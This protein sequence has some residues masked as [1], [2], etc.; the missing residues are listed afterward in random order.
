MSG[1]KNNEIRTPET[2]EAERYEIFDSPSY[3]FNIE[4]RDFLKA[5][6]GGVG[7]FLLV[8]APAALAQRGRESGGSR[9]FHM[10]PLP[11]NVGAWLH[12]APGGAVTVYT[13][14]VEIG[15]NIRTSLA[16]QVAQEL[17]VKLDTIT[18]VMGD[19]TLVPWDIGTFGSLTTPTMGPQLRRVGAVARD[20][21]IE[22]AA[23]RWRANK[24][25][26]V[27]ENGT[28]RDP[29][30]GRSIGYGALAEGQT[31]AKTILFDDP[32]MS[33]TKWTIAGEP[34]P[35]VGA[36]NFVTGR[37]LYPYDIKRPGMMYGKVLRPT[38]FGATLVSLDASAAK[39]IPGVVV[40]HDG[41][42]VGVVAP[43]MEGAE[44]A[45]GLLKATWRTTPQISD[46]ELF[47]YLKENALPEN[48][49]QEQR[50]LHSV[51]SVESGM[52]A[53]HQRFS[54]TYTIAYI[55]HAPLEPRATVAEWHGDKLTVWTGTQRPFAVRDE[56][57]EAFHLPKD[58][59]HLM[60]PDMGSGYG[61]KHTGG[62]TVEAARLAKAA[63]KPVKLNWTREEEFTWA[64]FRP[65]G[66]IE[67]RA[68]LDAAGKI[69]AWEMINYNS[70]PSAVMTP[71]VIP[72]QTV[73][74]RPTKYPLRQGSYR[75]LAATANFFA[76]ESAMGELAHMAGTDQLEFRLKHLSD[77]RLKTVFRAAAEKFGWPRKKT[78]PGQGFGMGGGIEKGG[79]VAT[80]AEVFLDPK[81]GEV[82]IRHVV[83]AWECGAIVNPDG[84]NNQVTGAQVMGIGG[85]LF[86][87]IQ[88]A[89]GKIL[90]PLFS[91]YRVPR[92][93]DL[94]KIDVVLIDRKDRPPAG[95][96]E[97]P[98]T[99]LAPAVGNAIFDATGV[100]L[101]SMPLAPH[102]VK[103]S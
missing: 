9:R 36:I 20:T 80:C 44:K 75:A 65:A 13:G 60:M 95:A 85:A 79:R 89:D 99:G 50:F 77:E 67:V 90:N 63:G 29:S 96:G 71:Y 3:H 32:L 19:T 16:Q 84:L 46:K 43:T 68:G 24:S 94:P 2:I 81:D 5:V 78:A 4:R 92:F 23:E 93:S 42:F 10:P 27:A 39:A 58:H 83:V 64:Y 69:I 45:L 91:S 88:F 26:L 103:K 86:E 66:V 49:Q 59:V 102:G 30:T 6:G 100:R 74:F 73:G 35:K 47:S 98:M 11:K 62:H 41:N 51:G 97:T 22:L 38:A 72:N 8:N 34:I 82:H 70:G 37:H 48:E 25:Q 56:C 31:L 52:A 33:P 15:Q 87:H 76:R 7:V 14:K 40:V 53:A 28:I 54:Q 17:H 18:M 1:T 55:A 61:G 57:A 21:M 12:I 101:R